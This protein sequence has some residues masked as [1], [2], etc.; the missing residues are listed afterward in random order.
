MINYGQL[1]AAV[2]YHDLYDS[3]E[4]WYLHHVQYLRQVHVDK[5]GSGLNKAKVYVLKRD[6]EAKLRQQMQQKLQP[7]ASQGAPKSPDCP[8]LVSSASSMTKGRPTELS[9][10]SFLINIL[11]SDKSHLSYF[12]YIFNS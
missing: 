4:L 11:F 1:C 2:T 5:K 6:A 3:R 8:P 7:S 9:S 12:I 10:N